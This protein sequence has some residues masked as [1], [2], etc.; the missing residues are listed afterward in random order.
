MG[1]GKKFFSMLE[2]KKGDMRCARC[3]REIE[4]T[5][6]FCEYC[7]MPVK[8]GNFTDDSKENLW[9]AGNGGNCPFCGGTIEKEDLFCANCG[10]PVSRK[11]GQ[12]YQ[13]T[14]KSIRA[15]KKKIRRSARIRIVLLIVALAI[16]AALGI[17]AVRYII[18][19]G[20]NKN[21]GEFSAGIIMGEAVSSTET[22]A[23][24]V[25]SPVSPSLP[26]TD[27]VSSP[28]VPTA[29]S[30]AEFEQ[31]EKQDEVSDDNSIESVLSQTVEMSEEW[32]PP[33]DMEAQIRT[34]RGIYDA[35][36]ADISSGV[37]KKEVSEGVTVY[38]EGTEIKA[39]VVL[40]G[41]DGIAY[42]RSYYFDAGRLF[43]AYYEDAD[44]HRFYFYEGK[45]IRW[46]YSV[47]AKEAQNAINHDLEKTDE[48]FMWERDVLDSA[49]GYVDSWDEK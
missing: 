44:A 46:R 19:K 42:S 37:L 26:E 10:H 6:K 1:R 33:E 30:A 7:G 35:I 8:N 43:F 24:V 3:G 27:V 20:K 13:D 5:A 14:G 12:I 23:P 4:D 2:R 21:G 25:Q 22:D 45:L 47:N 32:F 38:C 31:S 11:N 49:Q 9:N 39:I 34:I 29:P 40:K 28:V 16:M 17:L 18:N 48:Y 36:V 15:E 41:V